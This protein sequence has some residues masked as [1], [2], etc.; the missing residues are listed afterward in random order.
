M[1]VSAAELPA[2]SGEAGIDNAAVRSRLD[3]GLRQIAYFVVPSA[4]AF[5]A[6]GDVIASALFQ[7]GRFT[8]D[9]AIFVW[10]IVAGSSVGLVASTLG[11]LYSSTFYALR[12][13]STPL[14]FAVIRVILTVGL[15]LIAAFQ[16][17][18]LLG[19]E[20]RWGTAGLTASAGVAGWVE[21]VLL[22][23]GINARIGATGIPP[24]TLARL[25]GSAL[26]GAIVAWGAKL[27]VGTE[28][29]LLAAVAVLVPY[30]V[31]YLGLTM[32]LGVPEAKGALSRVRRLRR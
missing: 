16:L 15:G 28:H 32:V 30:G 29:P 4:V 10:G 5:I 31:I 27:L 17:P 18:P 2:M 12:D 9:D 23:R 6:L 3:A 22:R 1:S 13:T 26:I 19:I 7:T 24:S 21:F 14:R 25:W 11:R 8:R 20:P